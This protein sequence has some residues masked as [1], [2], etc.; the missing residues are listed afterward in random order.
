MTLIEICLVC[1][2][3]LLALI[4]AALVTS[5]AC[6]VP[7]QAEL[8]TML[9]NLRKSKKDMNIS[10]VCGG[11]GE[12]TPVPSW[13]WRAIFLVLLFCG[14]VGLIAYIIL[15]ICMPPPQET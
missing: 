10:G 6:R 9:R 8:G 5:G 13:I 15:A 1:I 14:G 3:I 11:L 7:N 12:H 4:L 2:V